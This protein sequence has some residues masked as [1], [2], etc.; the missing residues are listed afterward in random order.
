MNESMLTFIASEMILISL[1]ISLLT[2]YTV[3]SLNLPLFY[4]CYFYNFSNNNLFE[5][6]K[7]INL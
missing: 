5:I 7:I 1:L 3:L 4:T 2:R 6:I